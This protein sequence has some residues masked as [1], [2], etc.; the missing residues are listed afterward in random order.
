MITWNASFSLKTT[1][2][3]T[4]F[5]RMVNLLPKIV[6]MATILHFSVPPKN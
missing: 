5:T 2:K 4:F 1:V 3:N 6:V